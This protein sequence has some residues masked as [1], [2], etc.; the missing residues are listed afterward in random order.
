MSQVTRRAVSILGSTGSVGVQALD[1]IGRFPDR[2]EVVAL[3]AGRNAALLARQIETHRPRLAAIDDRG[4]AAALT[5]AARRA[6]C[7]IVTGADGLLA[8]ASFP[9]AE[10]VLA[11]VVGSAGLPSTYH[12]LKAGK[13]VALANKESLVMAGALLQDVVRESGGRLLPVDSEHSAVHQC[14]R[15]GSTEG[16]ARIILTASGGPFRTAPLESLRTVTPEQ[17]LRHP[18]WDMG[19]KISVDSATLMNK[20]LEVIE[21]RWLFGLEPDRLDVVLHPQS[22]VHSMVEM[23]DGSVLSQMGVP[24]MR[25]PI[26][27]ALGYPDRFAGPVKAPDLAAL[28]ALEFFPV[29]R[30][31]YP[32]LDLAYS[33]LKMGGTSPAALNAVNEVA[34]QAFL[35]GRLD[36]PG[37]PRV[38]EKVLER[39]RPVPATSLAS[40]Q[41]AD[42]WARGVAEEMVSRGGE[43]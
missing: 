30:R 6:R 12:A 13:C 18:V 17:A 16:V 27:Y 22:I 26:Q 21:A 8:A 23:V 35:A 2:F 31:R 1:L 4:G 37:I 7:E 10:I 33:A 36:F 9:G 40:V 3:A 39:H 34:V 15:G 28:G 19:K 5:E 25:G 14:L 41:E 42:A 38:V 32:C 11:A 29:D 43:C 24:D 20:G